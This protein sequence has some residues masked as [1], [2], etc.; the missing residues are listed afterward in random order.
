MLRSQKFTPITQKKSDSVSKDTNKF[1][2]HSKTLNIPPLAGGEF[3][4]GIEGP[5][6][7]RIP[8]FTI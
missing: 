5:L 2:D 1:Y 7:I 3:L 6:W 8:S 4:R